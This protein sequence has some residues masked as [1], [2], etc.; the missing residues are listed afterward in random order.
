[1]GILPVAPSSSRLVEPGDRKLNG[2]AEIPMAAGFMR[3]DKMYMN[4]LSEMMFM[5]IRP[6]PKRALELKIFFQR[7]PGLRKPQ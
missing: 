4:A 7:E 3:I 5:T 1:M 6:G 2:F